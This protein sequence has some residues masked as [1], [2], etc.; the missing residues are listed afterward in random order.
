MQNKNFIRD[1]KLYRSN[2]EK[3]KAIKIRNDF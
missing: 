2:I 1:I 3:L